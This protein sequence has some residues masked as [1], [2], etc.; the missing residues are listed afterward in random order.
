MKIKILF[1]FCAFFVAVATLARDGDIYYK[2]DNTDIMQ[3]KGAAITF[4][5][6][7]AADAMF[8]G[9]QV[10]FV[11]PEGFKVRSEHPCELGEAVANHNPELDLSFR[12]EYDNGASQQPTNIFMGFQISRTPL[13]VGEGIKL[14]TFYVETDENVDLGYFP[15]TTTDLEFGDMNSGLSYHC[16]QKTHT[17]NVIPYTLR[18]LYEDDTDIPEKNP[19]AE[20]IILIKSINSDEWTCITFPFDLSWEQVE[21]AFGNDVEIAK[22]NGYEY[23]DNGNIVLKCESENGSGLS[24][25]TPYLIKCN[26]RWKEFQF[27]DVIVDSDEEEA[28]LEYDNGK[29][30]KSREVY[31]YMQGTLHK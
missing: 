30:G 15:F 23:D 9:F 20:D 11:L 31:A 17:L 28:I 12:K 5:Y 22:F 26:P 3:G 21:Y 7:A 24:K 2:V 16:T 14:F 29:I 10:K 8:N 13:P 19:E 6:D 1:T 27:I 25:N 4:Y 18:L